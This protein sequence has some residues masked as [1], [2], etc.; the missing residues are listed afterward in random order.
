MT[1]FGLASIRRSSVVVATASLPD[2]LLNAARKR[3]ASGV[4]GS[5]SMISPYC[6]AASLSRPSPASVPASSSRDWMSSGSPATAALAC[7]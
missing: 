6:V 4:P 5:R 1:E 7:S 2:L 3:Y